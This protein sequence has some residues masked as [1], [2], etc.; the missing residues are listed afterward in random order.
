MIRRLLVLV[1]L[2]AVVVVGPFAGTALAHPLG[3]FTVNHYDGLTLFSDHVT[4]HA[5]VDVAEIPT[6]QDKPLADT[7]GDGVISAAEGS[8]FAARECAQLVGGLSAS[9]GDSPLRWVVRSA[10]VAY[11]PGQAGLATTRLTCELSALAQLDRVA[12]LSF[13]DGYRA[14]RVGWHEITAVGNGVRLLNPQVPATSVSDELRR[15]P[16][17]LLSSPLGVRSVTLRTQPG[18][19]VTGGGLG[20]PLPTVGALERWSGGVTTLFTDL[21][22]RTLTPLVGG[23]AVL[24]ALVVGAAHAALPGHGK[25]VMAAYL[26]GRR[27]TRRDAVLVG[28]TVTLTHTAGV[29][30]L[31]LMLTVFSSLVPEAVLGWLGVVSG[32]LVAGIGVG[33]LRSALLQRSAARAA[34]VPATSALVPVGVGAPAAIGHGHGHGHGHGDSQLAGR[35]YGRGA[36]VAMGVA[37]GLVP[38]PT[39]L[40]VLFSAVALGRT[41][42]GVVLVVCYGA[43]MAATLTAAGLIL[44]RVRDHLDASQSSARLRQRAAGLMAVLPVLTALLVL[45]VGLGLAASSIGATG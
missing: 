10:A 23:L 36:L 5:V 16:N 41:W 22:G 37:G 4:D 6:L 13:S 24:M 8:A 18:S 3:N 12:N 2:I 34:V 21:A 42:F 27:G 43:G 45:I 44:V 20:V 26:A 28:A 32:L 11:S 1:G 31:G 9:A 19:G 29:L 40:V 17:D 33:L 39:A 35:R 14:D 15:Y 38:S 30:A 7:D 25:T